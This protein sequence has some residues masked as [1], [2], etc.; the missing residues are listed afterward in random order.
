MKNLLLLILIAVINTMSFTQITE[1]PTNYYNYIS[2]LAMDGDTL[3]IKGV[4]N[5]FAKSYDMGNNITVFPNNLQTGRGYFDLKVVDNIYYLHEQRWSPYFATVMRS[6]DLGTSWDTLYHINGLNSSLAVYDSSHILFG[7]SGSGQLS[8]I[9]NGTTWFEP[10]LPNASGGIAD[11]AYLNKDTCFVLGGNFSHISYDGGMTWDWSY[12][13][14]SELQKVIFVSDD[15]I[16]AAGGTGSSF[17]FAYSY[18]MGLNS[19]YFY[20]I[21]QAQNFKVKDLWFEN[22]LHGYLFGSATGVNDPVE[23]CAIFETFDRGQTWSVMRL[24]YEG[25]LFCHTQANDSI[26]FLGGSK[27]LLSE[28]ILLKWNRN[29]PLGSVS[30]EKQQEVNAFSIYPN[31]AKNEIFIESPFN[32]TSHKTIIIYDISGKVV[33]QLPFEKKINI[34]SLNTGVYIVVIKNNDG[35]LARQKLIVK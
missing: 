10:T 19:N 6:L 2:G 28:P 24:E 31:P 23:K 12:F 3:L 1:I 16:Y 33:K 5:Y 18:N 8:V 34:E 22:S 26:F 17:M 32:L 9:Y 21:S 20:H 7:G 27:A 30:I 35:V 29:Q 25:E 15:T 11:A 14:G 13:S 4:T